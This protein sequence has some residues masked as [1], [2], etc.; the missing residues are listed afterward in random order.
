[1]HERRFPLFG[2]SL[3]VLKFEVYMHDFSLTMNN[4]EMNWVLL[5]ADFTVLDHLSVIDCGTTATCHISWSFWLSSNLLYEVGWSSLQT[6]MSNDGW[7]ILDLSALKFFEYFSQNVTGHRSD[8]DRMGKR[9][10]YR[11]KTFSIY[12]A[13]LFTIGLQE[14]H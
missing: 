3:W 1:M 8:S 10:L 5:V 11:L 14:C 13:V 7:L 4:N 9:G 12:W 2:W 6:K